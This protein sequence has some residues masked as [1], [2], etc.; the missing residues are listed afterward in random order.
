MAGY[1]ARLQQIILGCGATSGYGTVSVS[2]N[3][4]QSVLTVM[5][6]VTVRTLTGDRN[7]QSTSQ[8][9]SQKSDKTNRPN[10]LF[11]FSAFLL[12]FLI[13]CCKN[14]YFWPEKN[15]GKPGKVEGFLEAKPS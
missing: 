1:A 8:N 6:S 15:P 10:S 14:F 4:T 7:S 12:L 3:R 9:N 11:N 13:F 2:L 5:H